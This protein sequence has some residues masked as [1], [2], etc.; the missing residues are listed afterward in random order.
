M[1]NDYRNTKYC[2]VL[3]NIKDEKEKL[4]N[5]IREK[6]PRQKNMYNKISDRSTEYNARFAKIYNCKCAYCGVSMKVL[7][8]ILFEVDH[9]IAESTYADKAQA[10]KVENLVLA[11]YQCNRSKKDFII[12]DEYVKRLCTD[13][14]SIADV[15]YRD[16][17]YYICIND[18][19]MDDE[20]VKKFYEQLHLEHQSRRLD[21]LLMNMHGL[22]K[23]MQ[24][25]D[26]G[27][28]LAEAIVLLQEKRNEFRD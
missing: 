2:P 14:G 11:C 3:E 18:K 17:N 26:K 20:T 7:S 27:G 1:I 8:S 28:K 23:Q 5:D 10:G 15:F 19:Y 9:Y 4:E 12:K 6:H 25:T 16:S 21:Y 13:N 22:H 24:G